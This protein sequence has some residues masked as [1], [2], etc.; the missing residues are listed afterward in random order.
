MA[1]TFSQG[2]GLSWRRLVSVTRALYAAWPAASV[3]CSASSPLGYHHQK[4]CNATH[5]LLSFHLVSCQ[6]IARSEQ[7]IQEHTQTLYRLRRNNDDTCIP[8][9]KD[10]ICT[11]CIY[12]Y[13]IRPN[14]ESNTFYTHKNIKYSSS[15]N[16]EIACARVASILQ[17][18]SIDGNTHGWNCNKHGKVQAC[19]S[20]GRALRAAGTANVRCPK[21]SNRLRI[22]VS[23][24]ETNYWDFKFEYYSMSTVEIILTKLLRYV[25]QSSGWR[26]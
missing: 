11:P 19:E 26:F 6:Q 15:Q 23:K 1:A 4:H 17:D 5:L 21:S 2:E 24:L 14:T 20:A 12:I 10:C 8:I 9:P 18:G 7:N 3:S 13:I 16:N 22:R 25:R